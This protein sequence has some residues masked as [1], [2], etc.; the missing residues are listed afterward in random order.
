MTVMMT[1]GFTIC[2]DVSNLSFSVILNEN[3][4]EPLCKN[5]TVLQETSPGNTAGGWTMIEKQIYCSSGRKAAKVRPRNI[6]IAILGILPSLTT[7]F[8]E[9]PGLVRRENGKPDAL[10]HKYFKC[11]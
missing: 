2:R 4:S 8:A 5:F 6:N 3:F 1:K 7:Y 11:L 9:S 10:V